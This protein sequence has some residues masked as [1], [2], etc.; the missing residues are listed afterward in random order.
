MDAQQIESI[1]RGEGFVG[2]MLPGQRIVISN[3]ENG[4]ACSTAMKKLLSPTSGHPRPIT[5][6]SSQLP[7][8]F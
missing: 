6:P 2:P 4:N 7:P 5:L 8:I 3:G 1:L